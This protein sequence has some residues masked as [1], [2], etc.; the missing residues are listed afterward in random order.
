M[1]IYN[2]VVKILIVTQP[3]GNI[4]NTNICVHTIQ[5]SSYN[6]SQRIHDIKYLSKVLAVFSMFEVY[7]KQ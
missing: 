1:H 3:F 7:L 5:N 6:E 4:C 2:D